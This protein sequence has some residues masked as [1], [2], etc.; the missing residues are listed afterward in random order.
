MPALRCRLVCIADEFHLITIALLESRRSCGCITCIA[1][2]LQCEF[3]HYS[4]K[5]L[6]ISD[7]DRRQNYLFD[8]G[9]VPHMTRL[10]L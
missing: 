5:H 9:G 7:F 6:K 2:E 3:F 4:Q 10:K 1:V 8:Q